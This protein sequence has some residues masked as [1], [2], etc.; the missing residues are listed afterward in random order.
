MNRQGYYRSHTVNEKLLELKKYQQEFIF[1]DRI[2]E[3]A[4]FILKWCPHKKEQCN[5][6]LILAKI[7]KKGLG[8][9]VLRFLE[10]EEKGWLHERTVE[11]LENSILRMEGF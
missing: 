11:I 7:V 4:F 10:N 5:T 3:S 6:A 9:E 8:E 2:I 1:D